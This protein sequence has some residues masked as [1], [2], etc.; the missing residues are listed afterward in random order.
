[1]NEQIKNFFEVTK[2]IWGSL[3]NF[4]KASILAIG[5]ICA[6]GLG[7]VIYYG[8]QPQWHPLYT[9]VDGANMAKIRDVLVDSNVPYKLRDGGRTIEIPVQFVSEMKV[10]VQEQDD[11]TVDSNAVDPYDY[12]YGLDIGMGQEEKKIAWLKAQQR[13][14]EN[15]IRQMPKVKGAKVTLNI[16]KRRPFE[17]LKE[18]TATVMLNVRG[19]DYI[20]ST[21]VASVQHLV[22]SAV[23]NLNHNNV[24]VVDSNG[25][26]LARPN[27]D[28]ATRGALVEDRRREMQAKLEHHLQ[29]KVQDI[30]APAVGGLNK[31]VARIDVNLAFQKEEKR[32]EEFKKDESVARSEE[33]T[34]EITANSSAANSSGA[35]GT[36]GNRTVKVSVAAPDAV[37]GPGE[38]SQ[39]SKS[40]TKK[41]YEIPST[42][43]VILKDGAEINKLSVSVNVASPDK[44]EWGPAQLAKFE[45]LVKSAVGYVSDVNSGRT[46][47]I[48]VVETKFNIPQ[49]STVEATTMNDV[50]EQVDHYMD[51]NI[52]RNV[53]GGLLLVALLIFYKKIFSSEKVESQDI[54]G[55]SEEGAIQ[56]EILDNRGFE[57]VAE[58]AEIAMIEAQFDK[59]MEAIKEATNTHPQSIATVIENWVMKES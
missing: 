28:E 16:P 37:D 31:V 49:P 43:S 55:G 48:T 25:R 26:L 35:V 47:S 53:M 40:T 54:V 23:H 20:G 46:D 50:V 42:V 36:A 12:I 24:T 8:S 11:I 52:A 59:E 15:Q 7:L 57:E 6:S 2:G 4:Q 1:M 41:V 27:N 19:G 45:D 39:L 30:L 29:T 14:L 17:E 13:N 44:G 32:I 34:N 5:L 21:Q 38:S 56:G 3:G 51:T 58:E 33:I 18:S 9:N 10:K 22:A